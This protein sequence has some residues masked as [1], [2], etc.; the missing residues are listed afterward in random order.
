[1]LLTTPVSKRFYSFYIYTNNGPTICTTKCLFCQRD[2]CRSHRGIALEVTRSAKDGSHITVLSYYV[3]H[4]RISSVL[5]YFRSIGLSIGRS[6]AGSFSRS[7]VPSEKEN[8]QKNK[9]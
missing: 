3:D 2:G 7:V 1:M 6:L 8:L 5:S 9:I 4:E